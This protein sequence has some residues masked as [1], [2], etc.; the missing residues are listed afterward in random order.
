M[1]HANLIALA[2]LGTQ[3]HSPAKI[4]PKLR[5]A[6]LQPARDAEAEGV[7]AMIEQ[8]QR[9]EALCK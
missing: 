9:I 1:T 3:G 4:L 5:D 8:H 2:A 6:L 7:R